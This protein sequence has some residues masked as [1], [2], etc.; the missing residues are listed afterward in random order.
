MSIAAFQTWLRDQGYAPGR[1]DGVRG[2]NT[3][4]A[5]FAYAWDRFLAQAPA[6]Q[7]TSSPGIAAIAAHEGIVPGPYLDDVGVWTWGIGHTAAAGAPDPTVMPRGMPADLDATVAEAFSVFARDLTKFEARVRQAITVPL[8]QHEFDAA[9]SFDFNTG[10][11]DNAD[12]V[13]SL[14]RGDRATAAREIMNF[15]K[16]VSVIPRRAAEQR[17]FRD[18]IYPS[19]PAPVWRV[20][21]AGNVI[22]KA[23][24][25]C[26]P[27]KSRH[28][29]L[30]LPDA[31]QAASSARSTA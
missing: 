10:R 5:A 7:R 21:T 3:T 25:P 1:S 9:V 16:P 17:L 13:R 19:R 30:R 23:V 6:V 22:W 29:W 28:G 31:S 2:P 26:R 15:K 12:W 24:M 18:G 8:A 27:R 14:N 4:E 11:I 20:D